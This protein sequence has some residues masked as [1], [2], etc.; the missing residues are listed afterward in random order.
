MR[1]QRI[2]NAT[3]F[4]SLQSLL[5]HAL[6]SGITLGLFG[7]TAALVFT[8]GGADGA[9]TYIMVLPILAGA[10]TYG[11]AG[12]IGTGAAAT[13]LLTPWMPF[14]AF[15]G[16]APTTEQ[17]VIGGFTFLLVGGVAG[18]LHSA[19][20]RHNTIRLSMARTDPETG[21]PNRGALKQDLESRLAAFSED[22]PTRLGVVLVRATDLEDL[23]D[24]VGIDGGDEVIRELGSHLSTV[25]PK[26]IGPYRFSSA[27]VALI[28]AI[29]DDSAV[30]HLARSIHK[31][32]SAA[33]TV[34]GA[35][36]RIEP[37]IGVGHAH[38]D[39]PVD[40]CELIRRA[41]I[42]LRRALILEQSWV[43]YEPRLDSDNKQT[44][45][46]IG[47]AED[48]L[49][50]GE[51]ELFYQPKIRLSNREPHGV[52]ALIRWRTADGGF[53]APATFMPKLEQTSLI[54]PFSRFVIREAI[55]F[56]RSG[57]SLPVSINLAPRNLAD[58]AITSFLINTLLTTGIP[59]S[60]IQVEMTEG[61]L[62]R[63][64]DT[65]I[66]LLVQLREHGVGV[67]IDDFGTGYASFAYLRRLPCTE[68]K[69]DRAFIAPIVGDERARRL[70]LA[71]VEV[72]EA[73]GL[74]VT[75]EGVET[76]GQA[77]ILSELGCH[78]GQ[79]F[80]WSPALP[81]ENLRNWLA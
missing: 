34:D 43:D 69:I 16:V 20:Y 3:P 79:G 38:V 31:A 27:E 39:T 59:G 30:R 6:R 48:A 55:E 41:R 67:S 70:V 75:A 11:L 51:F 42:A 8:T 68:L 19:L 63:D 61:A 73:L 50:G 40:A 22:A 37:A 49:E 10:Y 26:V 35:P 12:G 36:L 78:L 2:L 64:P 15:S 54:E 33:F 1:A 65:T 74:T 25:S 47:R 23:V 71:M 14:S 44:I 13:L 76:E 21:L 56:A 24:V 58:S 57:I 52:E 72:G 53:I 46:L 77:A 45:Q 32:A 4:G 66:G 9:Y 18:G 80:L 5:S 7:V 81:A 28:L 60:S 29:D 62:M 17:W